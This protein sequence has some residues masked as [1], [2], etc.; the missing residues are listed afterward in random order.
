MF[1]RCWFLILFLLCRGALAGP[2]DDG[3]WH[4][5]AYAFSNEMGGFHILAVSGTGTRS[6]PIVLV[7]ELTSASAVTLV[8]HAVH[9]IN[10]VGKQPHWATGMMHMRVVTVNNSGLPWIGF[11][12]ELQEQPGVPSTFGDGLSFDQR[13]LD[14][15]NVGMDRFATYE[16]QFEPYDRLEFLDGHV[17]PQDTVT[18]RFFISDFTPNLR[19][20]LVQDPLVPFS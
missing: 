7:Q 1:L 17:D 6:D 5:G 9:P 11:S 15:A 13:K 12:F 8:I 2:A 16:R 4:T 3:R 18:F 14:S 19:T 10:P 20:Y